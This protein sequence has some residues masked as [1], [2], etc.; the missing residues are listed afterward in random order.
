MKISK[1]SIDDLN[2]LIRITIE[3]QDYESTV[4]EKLKDYKKKANMPGFRKGMVP[5]NLIRRMYGKAV[6][7]EEVNQ[8][9][10]RELTKYIS[11]EKLNILGEPLPSKDEPLNIDFD[12]DE[13]FEFAFDLGLSP[14]IT[15]DIEKIGKIPFYEI[16]LEE[17]LIDSQIQGYTNRFGM[18]EPAEQVGENE[19]V[20]GDFIQ[21]DDKG[22]I[23]EEGISAK[24][25]QISVQLVKDDKIKKQFMGQKSERF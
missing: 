15:I 6:M 1:T 25:V 21:L 12:K 23:I 5:A 11:D 17:E 13:E 19:T 24:D 16:S 22:N 20:I 4:N 3:K 8:I 14:E 7:A 9:L 2:V 10:G 18:N